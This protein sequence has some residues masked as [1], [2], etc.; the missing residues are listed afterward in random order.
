MTTLTYIELEHAQSEY[1]QIKQH[2]HIMQYYIWVN[3]RGQL[4]SMISNIRG[5]CSPLRSKEGSFFYV[6]DNLIK[7]VTAHHDIYTSRLVNFLWIKTTTDGQTDH[8]TPCACV[9]GNKAL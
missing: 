6:S 1:V 5:P 7:L 8:F 3:R 9:Q 4:L 2:M